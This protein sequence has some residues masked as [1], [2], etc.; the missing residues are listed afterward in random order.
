MRDEVFLCNSSGPDPHDSARNLCAKAGFV[1]DI[2]YEGE[3]AE[4]I[5]ETV[6]HG[7]G[8][9]FVSRERYK[10]FHNRALAPDWERDLV[11]V[12]LEDPVCVRT[13]Y[14][15]RRSSGYYSQASTAFHRELVEYL[16][17]HPYG[18]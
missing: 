8:I 5:G 16:S 6:A 13:I 4:L 3:S 1:P 17:S 9:S 7:R 18:E 10:L 14:L 2:L 12:A 11:F 15:L